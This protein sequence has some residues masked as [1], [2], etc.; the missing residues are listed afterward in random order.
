MAMVLLVF[1]VFIWQNP[2]RTEAT[3]I[4][5]NYWYSNS[6]RIGY[7]TNTAFRYYVSTEAL[8]TQLS[9]SNLASYVAN[10]TGWR[11]SLGTG[12]TRVYTTSS[13]NLTVIGKS[14]GYL[15]DGTVGLTVY[16]G[17]TEVSTGD[18]NGETKSI[19]RLSDDVTVIIG[20]NINSTYGTSFY[21]NVMA[22][23]LTHALGYIGHYNTAVSGRNL[24]NT[25]A[26]NYTGI[27]PS[28]REVQH[29]TQVY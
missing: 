2:V 6:S 23:E 25:Y 26:E 13:A 17:S 27:L 9:V 1:G 16:G 14:Y 11:D 8:Y 18:Y 12:Y 15:P 28:T 20:E 3:S 19:E 22:H 29:L 24:M 10:S 21:Q 4:P 7:R 5:L